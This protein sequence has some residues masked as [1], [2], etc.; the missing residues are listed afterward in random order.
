MHHL[1][2]RL[3]YWFGKYAHWS[4]LLAVILA[5]GFYVRRNYD[6]Y[7]MLRDNV[8]LGLIV[9]LAAPFVVFV[10]MAPFADWGRKL[11]TLY[12]LDVEPEHKLRLEFVKKG[13]VPVFTQACDG[14]QKGDMAR[15][16]DPFFAECVY[17]VVAHIAHE[18]DGMPSTP[19]VQE[20]QRRYLRIVLGE[21]DF[22]TAL[23][24]ARGLG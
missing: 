11:V 15:V 22:T 8:I 5:I 17:N 13:V 21:S 3:L 20:A 12:R 4:V 7:R 14:L 9:I 18:F 10:V 1:K 16:D 6:V 2:C 24:R 23:G 19:Q